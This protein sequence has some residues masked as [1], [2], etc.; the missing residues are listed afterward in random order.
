M[1]GIDFSKRSGDSVGRRKKLKER[2]D[3]DFGI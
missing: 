1:L 2:Y 3:D